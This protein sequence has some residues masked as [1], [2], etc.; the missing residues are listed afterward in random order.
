MGKTKKKKKKKTHFLRLI[1]F[2][3]NYYMKRQ[4]KFNKGFICNVIKYRKIKNKCDFLALYYINRFK[5]SVPKSFVL[6]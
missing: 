5:Y 6:T 4:F 3:L 2:Q 1:S